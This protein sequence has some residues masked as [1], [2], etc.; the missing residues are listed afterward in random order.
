[1]K[2]ASRVKVYR[3]SAIHTTRKFI[4]HMIIIL[5]LWF[6]WCSW[7]WFWQWMWVNFQ[8]LWNFSNVA[9]WF[10]PWVEIKSESTAVIVFTSH[11]ISCKFLAS[12]RWNVQARDYAGV[13]EWFAVPCLLCAAR[14]VMGSSP[15]PPQ[16]LADTS[17]G[18]WIKKG[19]AAMLISIQSAGVALEVNLRNSAQARKCASKIFT[20]ALKP[21]E[22]VT[23]S[24]KQ[25]YQWLHEKDLCTPKFF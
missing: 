20:L 7:N 13:P 16:M 3:T 11:F 22:D 14:T 2:F 8:M 1:M 25:G 23:V 5:R 9:F 19:L 4:F 12:K 24:P 17:A 21:R 10:H 18:T 6:S 15:E